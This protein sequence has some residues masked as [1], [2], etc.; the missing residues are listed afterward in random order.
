MSSDSEVSNAANKAANNSKESIVKCFPKFLSSIIFFTIAIVSILFVII[1]L[2]TQRIVIAP[3]KTASVQ[4]ITDYVPS[5]LNLRIVKKIE[6]IKEVTRSI[7]SNEQKALAQVDDI[8]FKAKGIE[9]SFIK[10]LAPI[11]A[12]LGRSDTR[13][14]SELTCYQPSCE[15]EIVR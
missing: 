12:F 4:K 8:T 10:L 11:K 2:Y 9:F 15:F 13:V 3:L 5:N 6:H 7:T 14:T 1:E